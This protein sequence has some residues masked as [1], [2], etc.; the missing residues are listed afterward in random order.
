MRDSQLILPHHRYRQHASLVMVL[1]NQCSTYDM[2]RTEVLCCDAVNNP[3]VLVFYLGGWV[4]G[5][6]TVLTA[7]MT[8]Q[9]LS[10]CAVMLWTTLM[11]LFFTWGGGWGGGTTVLTAPMTWQGLRCCEQCLCPCFY[12]GG[13]VGGRGNHCLNSTYDMTRTE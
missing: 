10:S 2:T 8:W 11:S 3:C 7:P 12:L 6:T 13:W 9:G 1:V 4:G 5:G